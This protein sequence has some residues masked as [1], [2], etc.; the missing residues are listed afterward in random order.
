MSWASRLKLFLGVIV[1]LGVVAGCTLVFTQRQSAAQSATATIEAETLTVGA[2]YAGTV[3]DQLVQ[4]GDTVAAGDPLLTVHSVQL[5]RDLEDDVITPAELDGVD[6]TAGTYQVVATVD[7]TVA[8][9]DTPVGDFVTAGGTP[10]PSSPARRAAG[11]APVAE[12]P[13]RAHRRM[14]RH[15]SRATR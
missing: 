11:R 5:S 15:R 12:A 9:I 4:P 1:V 8:S 13:R 7:G 14:P 3:V 6:T 2:V 10:S